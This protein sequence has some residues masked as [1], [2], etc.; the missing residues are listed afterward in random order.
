MQRCVKL[1]IDKMQSLKHQVEEAYKFLIYYG[2]IF[3]KINR[4]LSFSP[5]SLEQEHRIFI[6]ALIQLSIVLNRP[7]VRSTRCN[8][9]QCLGCDEFRVYSD[10]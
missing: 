1:R 3:N 2:L 4:R 6:I 5:E 8:Y 9:Q 10:A 7:N